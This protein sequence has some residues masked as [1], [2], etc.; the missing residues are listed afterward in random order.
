M[1][2]AH[3]PG[4]DVD[5][6]LLFLDALESVYGFD[7]DQSELED[8]SQ[9]IKTHYET[10]GERMAELEAAEQSQD[11]RDFYADRMYM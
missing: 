3:P 11:D 10:L 5:A 2:P 4:P 6:A 8:L 7:V 9:E 1:T